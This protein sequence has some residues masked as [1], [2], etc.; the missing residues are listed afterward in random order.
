MSS[1]DCLRTYLWLPHS[2]LNSFNY[3]LW[4]NGENWPLDRGGYA[5]LTEYFGVTDAAEVE[6]TVDAINAKFELV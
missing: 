1:E 6:K 4:L 2:Q 3:A 5:N